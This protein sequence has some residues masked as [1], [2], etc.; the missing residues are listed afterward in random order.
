MDKVAFCVL[1]VV[2]QAMLID[3]MRRLQRVWV[4]VVNNQ[5]ALA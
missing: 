1:E 4:L 2:G 5:T 3:A